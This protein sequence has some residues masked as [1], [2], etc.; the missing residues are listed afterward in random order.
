[1]FV[2]AVAGRP[3]E[4]TL[5]AYA[6]LKRATAEPLAPGFFENLF[7]RALA[8]MPVGDSR[9]EEPLQHSQHVPFD[10]IVALVSQIPPD[11]EIAG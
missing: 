11:P 10:S 2:L 3:W 5:L 7:L 8:L 6:S 1:M 9:T 4:L